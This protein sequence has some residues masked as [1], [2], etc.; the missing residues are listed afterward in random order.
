MAFERVC[1]LSDLA[2]GTM[3]EYEVKGE[4]ILVIHTASGLVRAIP[5]SCPH[6]DTPLVEGELD[7]TTL[8]CSAHLWQFDLASGKGINPDDVELACF[9]VKVEDGAIY[10]DLEGRG[11]GGRAP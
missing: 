10:V 3:E 8:T 7:G 2:P 6:Q 9:P 4:E 1:N 11:K 5:A